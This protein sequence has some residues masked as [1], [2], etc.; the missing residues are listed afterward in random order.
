MATNLT[1]EWL[2]AAQTILKQTGNVSMNPEDEGYAEH[3]S[4]IVW[5]GVR[6][7]RR[8]YM[9]F[10]EAIKNGEADKPEHDPEVTPQR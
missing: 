10:A 3:R 9:K 2:K 1:R 4:K 7:F 8:G 6:A 5:R